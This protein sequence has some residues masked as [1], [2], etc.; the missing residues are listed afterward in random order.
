M[1]SDMLSAVADLQCFT[2][3]GVAYRQ[4]SLLVILALQAALT[5]GAI[6]FHNEVLQVL[7]QDVETNGSACPAEDDKV[8][9][10]HGEE[11]H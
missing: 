2:E 1:Q 7:N 9:N 10:V 6:C 4:L 8:I 5:I 3:A 11:Q